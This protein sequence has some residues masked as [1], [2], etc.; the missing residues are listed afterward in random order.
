MTHQTTDVRPVSRSNGPSR[1][2]RPSAH[3]VPGPLR[4]TGLA[5]LAGLMGLVTLVGCGSGGRSAATTPQQGKP[6]HQ[7]ASFDPSLAGFVA[8]SSRILEGTVVRVEDAGAG[9]MV[10]TLAVDGWV[11]PATGPSQVRLNLVDIAKDGVY[12]RWSPGSHLR[13]AVDVDP[14][15]LPSWQFSAAEFAAIEKAAPQGAE[16]RCPYGP[17]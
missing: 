10:A 7:P 16:L 2:D 11:K 3:R 8:C 4:A 1:R 5:G 13:L 12:Q 6:L 9:R 15:A 14:S 17:S